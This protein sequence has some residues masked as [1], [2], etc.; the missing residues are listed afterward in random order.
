MCQINDR[1]DTDSIALIVA[2]FSVC[3]TFS[4]LTLRSFYSRGFSAGVLIIPSKYTDNLEFEIL[5]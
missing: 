5:K 1:Y 4:I 3:K 2:T